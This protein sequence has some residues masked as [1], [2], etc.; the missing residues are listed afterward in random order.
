LEITIQKF[1]LCAVTDK[2]DKVFGLPTFIAKDQEAR[3]KKAL[4]LSR[5]LQGVVHDLGDGVLVVVKH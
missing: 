4:Y 2:P 1:I 3:Q 5:I